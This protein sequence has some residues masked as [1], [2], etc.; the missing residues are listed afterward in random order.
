MG[1]LEAFKRTLNAVAPVNRLPSE[2]LV[3]IFSYTMIPHPRFGRFSHYLLHTTFSAVCKHW[4]R[5]VLS[6]PLLWDFIASHHHPS[7]VEIALQRSQGVPL[8]ALI[9][10]WSEPN[11]VYLIQPHV[12]SI[13]HLTCD[14]TQAIVRARQSH[15]LVVVSPIL[16]R[17]E[18]RR[19]CITGWGHMVSISESPH[20]R[21]VARVSLPESLRSLSLFFTPLI[22]HLFRLT[23]LTSLSL[24]G[25]ATPFEILLLFLKNNICLEEIRIADVLLED[26]DQSGE[27]IPLPHL[28]DFSYS[29]DIIY[30][31]LHRLSAPQRAQFSLNFIDTLERPATVLRSIFPKSLASL[32]ILPIDFV[33]LQTDHPSSALSIYDSQGGGISVQWLSKKSKAV[34]WDLFDLSTVREVCVSTPPIKL[35]NP[36]HLHDIRTLLE[37]TPCLDTLSIFISNRWGVYEPS[38]LSMITPGSTEGFLP[39]LRNIR[40]ASPVRGFP[41][42]RLI[43]LVKTRKEAE[44]ISDIHHVEVL[45]LRGG[46]PRLEELES[47]VSVSVRVVDSWEVPAEWKRGVAN[48]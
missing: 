33:S 28:H 30:P 29:G 44:G 17:L 37:R 5:V 31:F 13:Q 24:Q 46:S 23:M 14:L 35:P 6:D 21:A 12:T 47:L 39:L 20:H 36:A 8:K 2:I 32:G 3:L 19:C 25:I 22:S 42:R 40:V 10:Q 9:G 27:T 34:N 7:M 43:N 18:L 11:F 1:K 38:V 48:R 26:A 41:L 16:E 45:I 15:P 4:R